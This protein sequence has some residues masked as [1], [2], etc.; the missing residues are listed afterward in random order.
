MSSSGIVVAADAPPVSPQ[1][2]TFT[3]SYADTQALEASGIAS[4]N[5]HVV[6]PN[7]FDES[8]ILTNVTTAP[9]GKTADATYSIS[10]PGGTWD[11]ADDGEYAVMMQPGQVRNTAGVGV[12][13]GAIGSF[14]VSL[15]IDIV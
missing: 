13:E 1:V 14:A 2:Y 4:G 5:V 9:D 6:G 7:G 15:P 12:P 11:G 3:V 8:A 10:P